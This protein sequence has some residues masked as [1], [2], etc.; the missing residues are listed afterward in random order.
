MLG[1]K[2]NNSKI[3]HR[4]HKRAIFYILS[5]SVKIYMY[6]FFGIFLQMFSK[7]K[8]PNYENFGPRLPIFEIQPEI[9]EKMCFKPI[10]SKIFHQGH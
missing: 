10:N 5:S 8:F 9:F 4:D 7:T 1:F 6:E 3:L 2:P